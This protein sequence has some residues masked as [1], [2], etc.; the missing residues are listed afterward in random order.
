[1]T[2]QRS[3]ARDPGRW[4][5]PGGRVE[6]RE[7]IPSAVVRELLEETQIIASPFRLPPAFHASMSH[8]TKGARD[9]SSSFP[10]CAAGSAENLSP[11]TIPPMPAG[12]SEFIVQRIAYS[13]HPYPRAR[14]HRHV[15]FSVAIATMVTYRLPRRSRHRARGDVRNL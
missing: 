1:M 3:H 10:C 14:R 4:C 8:Q 6:R 9:I 15:E 7:S 13:M 5:F 12:F 2:V 11:A